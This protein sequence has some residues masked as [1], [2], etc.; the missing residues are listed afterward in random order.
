[1]SER[2]KKKSD[3]LPRRT[4]LEEIGPKSSDNTIV[5]VLLL[6]AL[7]ANIIVLLNLVR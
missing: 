6:I 3:G 1:M 2:K 5:L 4:K 7:G